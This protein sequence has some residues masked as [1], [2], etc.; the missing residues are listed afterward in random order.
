MQ[1]QQVQV[2]PIVKLNF[3]KIDLPSESNSIVMLNTDATQRTVTIVGGLHEG[4]RVYLDRNYLFTGIPDALKGAAY[5]MSRNED[6][7]S[8]G[9]NLVTLTTACLV[10]VYIAHDRRVATSAKPDW[11]KQFAPTKQQLQTS[12]TGMA[13]FH[14]RFKAGKTIVL[15]GNTTDGT[16]SGKSNYV[17]V[18]RQT[19]LDPQPKP[20][21]R[22]EVLAALDQADAG[23]GRQIFFGQ[24]GPQCATCHEVDGAGNRR[25][26][27]G[28]NSVEIHREINLTRLSPA[29]VS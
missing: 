12:D 14:R 16:D 24:K 28:S 29:R 6:A 7:G 15:G 19:L 4:G 20:V 9:D 21:T 5:L 2:G 8:R 13:L 22:N 26:T 3:Q 18:F 11:L 25:A 1:V 23:R 17:A 27:K 10:D